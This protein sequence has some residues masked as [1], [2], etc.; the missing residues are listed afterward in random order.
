MA[1]RTPEWLI[2]DD[3]NAQRWYIVHTTEPAFIAEIFDN[4]DDEGIVGGFSVGLSNGQY[5]G[6]FNLW[7]DVPL[8]VAFVAVCHRVG[9]VL[10][11]YDFRI[12]VDLN[13]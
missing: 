11:E 7:S 2:A 8:D 4:D 1:K 13:E 5:L 12:G 6:N 9:P 3:S 10:D